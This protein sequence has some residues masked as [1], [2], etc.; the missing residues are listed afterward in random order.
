LNNG[1]EYLAV[2]IV[3]ISQYWLKAKDRGCD[4]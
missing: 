4:V 2:D 1:R 3:S